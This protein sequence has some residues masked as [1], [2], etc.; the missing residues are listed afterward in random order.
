MSPKKKLKELSDEASSIEEQPNKKAKVKVARKGC[1]LANFGFFGVKN[2]DLLLADPRVRAE[3]Y[4]K[5]FTKHEF[6]EA[7]FNEEEFKKL[8]SIK[9][10][11]KYDTSVIYLMTGDV[12]DFRSNKDVK[13]P[14]LRELTTEFDFEEVKTSV[15]SGGEAAF[16]V[17]RP[18]MVDIRTA[19]RSG[20]QQGVARILESDKQIVIAHVSSRIRTGASQ[21]SLTSMP[22][23][24]SLTD[25]SKYREHEASKIVSLAA[26]RAA[27]DL[28]ISDK[29][30]QIRA[31]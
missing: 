30:E 16:V 8:A 9:T 18:N 5:W 23:I 21:C 14:E 28:S 12:H 3:S 22:D 2:D 19:V 17:L 6:P 4:T 15:K 26:E 20:S 7:A 29:R 13:A 1:I 27:V 11:R 25:W 10:I 24:D 31:K